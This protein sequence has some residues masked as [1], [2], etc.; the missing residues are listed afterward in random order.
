IV[1]ENRS[2]DN[3]FSGYPGAD[4]ALSGPM[5]SGAEV[6]LHQT[7]LQGVDIWHNWTNAM[8][9]W[10]GGKMNGFDLNPLTSGG[11]A[12]TYPYAF[13]ARK[14]VAPYWTMASQYVLADHMFPTMF[15]P[16]FTGH[17]DLIAGTTDLS[18]SEAEV[19]GPNNQPWGCDAPA[20][21]R[22]SVIGPRRI[23]FGGSGPFPCFTQFRTLADTLDA[24]HISWRYYAPPV[25]ANSTG[26]IWSEF[27][28]IRNVRYGPDW[29]RNVISPQTRVLTDAAKGSLPAVAWVIPD[30]ADSDHV[31]QG[32][33]DGPSWVA[34]V[35]NAIGTGRQW[36]QTAIVVVWDDW[37]GWYDSIPPPQL[38]FRGLGIRVGCLIVSPYAKSHYVSHTVY[39][40]GSILKFVEQVFGLPPLGTLAEGYTDA[41]ANSLVDSFDFRQRPRAFKRIPAP[42]TPSYFLARPPSLVPPDDE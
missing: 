1:Q 27:D 12:R 15:G 22:T 3:L 14:L 13:V 36:K 11:Q 4:A 7:T 8:T 25:I 19:D 31:S 41:R 16:S 23:E 21:T 33:A 32:P 26:S 6:R 38:D 34:A 20:G 2:F 9:A 5:H 37:G 35:V 10:N 28:A 30:A 39:E 40:F 29:K 42:V 24:A 17:L 18:P